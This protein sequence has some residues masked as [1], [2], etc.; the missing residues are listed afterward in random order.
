MASVLATTNVRIQPYRSQVTENM[1]YLL[2]LG[3]HVRLVIILCLSVLVHMA[4]LFALPWTYFGSAPGSNQV[5]GSGN[6]LTVSFTSI[7]PHATQ[8][9]STAKI[10]GT[11]Q[12]SSAALTNDAGDQQT[13]L[14]KGLPLAFDARYFSTDELDQPSSHITSQNALDLPDHPQEGEI[15]LRLWLDKSG[16]VIKV[17]PVTPELSQAFIAGARARFLNSRFS[18]GRKSG[19]VVNT[20]IDITLRYG[21]TEFGSAN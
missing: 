17:E 14:N 21:S 4:I 5:A 15:I 3:S 19:G 2:H 10:K 1:E 7:P 12:D 9:N 8:Q 16:K 6:T 20:V 18:P 13:P 11:A